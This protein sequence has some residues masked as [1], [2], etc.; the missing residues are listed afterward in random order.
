[1]KSKSCTHNFEL[2]SYTG[3]DPVKLT[4][5]CVKCGSIKSRPASKLESRHLSKQSFDGDVHR[6]IHDFSAK[7]IGQNH[8]Y[9]WTGWDLIQRVERWAENKKDVYTSSCDDEV[10]SSSMI[11]YIDHRSK[12]AYMGTTVIFIPQNSGSIS[13]LFL[14]PGHLNEMIDVLTKIKK[15]SRPIMKAEKKSRTE[16]HRQW[17]RIFGKPEK[18][19]QKLELL[20]AVFDS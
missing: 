14:Y 2:S 20:S 8:E 16:R 11:V 18:E 12:K 10:F 19:I 6:T 3:K 4:L 15:D 9:K 13:Q 17:L 1:M 7:F 5:R